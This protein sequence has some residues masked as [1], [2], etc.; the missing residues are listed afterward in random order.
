M[1]NNEMVISST[2]NKLNTPGQSTNTLESSKKKENKLFGFWHS[3]QK[4]I[5]KTK[6]HVI[7]DEPTGWKELKGG[8]I[9]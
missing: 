2:Q 4:E 3:N 8:W 6:D 5:N 1:K 9:D 7:D